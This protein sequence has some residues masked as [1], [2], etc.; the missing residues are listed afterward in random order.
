M[1]HKNIQL[2]IEQEGGRVKRR[3]GPNKTNMTVVYL[4]YECCYSYQI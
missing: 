2:K 1:N 3:D 4:V